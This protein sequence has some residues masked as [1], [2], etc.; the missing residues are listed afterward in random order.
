MPTVGLPV[1]LISPVS[2]ARNVICTRYRVLRLGNDL[3]R[4]PLEKIS[5]REVVSTLHERARTTAGRALNIVRALQPENDWR[6]FLDN[7]STASAFVI[8]HHLG[9]SAEKYVH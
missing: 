8:G 7:A 9:Y 1:S 2:P 4:L 5:P 3:P 6:S